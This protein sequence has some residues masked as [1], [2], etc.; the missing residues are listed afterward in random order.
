MKMIR[1]RLVVTV[2]AIQLVL[3]ISQGRCE[4][5]PIANA[6]FELPQT[7]FV[8]VNIDSW[9]K[10]PKPAWY[11]ESGGQTWE[12]LTGVFLNVPPEDP[13]HIDNCDGYQAAWL[14]AVP[15][16]ELFQ[17]L[18]DAFEVGYAYHLTVGVIGGGG[19]MKDTVPMEIRLYY[20]DVE[21]NKI[22]TGSIT[23][24][25]DASVGLVKH[26]VDV[27]LDIPCVKESDPWAGK[28]IG[29]QMISTLILADLDPETGRAGGFWDID[30]VRLNRSATVVDL[31]GD[32]FVDFADFAVLAQE[33]LL[34]ANATADVT[35]DG[36]VDIDDVVILT[37]F[38]LQNIPSE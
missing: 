7:T 24:A 17:D 6:S 8:D 23:Y 5:I 14:F 32:S 26:F 3:A 13:A 20:R 12:Q 19:G 4:V 28:N 25:Y 38:W 35:A 1:Q 31:T 27:E 9:Q 29:V 10:G 2:I 22:P 18:N 16:V 15:E 37:E 30:N 21:G 36:C 11:A 34:C 33:W